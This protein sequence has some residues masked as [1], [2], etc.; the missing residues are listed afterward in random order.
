MH[1]Q[2]SGAAQRRNRGIAS[3]ETEALTQVQMSWTLICL[4]A[5]HHWGIQQDKQQFTNNKNPNTNNT[6]HHKQGP[7]HHQH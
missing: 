2:S 4:C 6:D 5:W 1:L 7:H 3:A